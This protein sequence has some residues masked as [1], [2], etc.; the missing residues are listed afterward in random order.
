[1]GDIDASGTSGHADIKGSGVSTVDCESRPVTK[2]AGSQDITVDFG[3]CLPSG[4]EIETM[5][6]CSDQDTIHVCVKDDNV[7][8]IKICGD[9]K[10]KAVDFV[11]VNAESTCTGGDAP[12]AQSEYEG[13]VSVLGHGETLNVKILDI[14]T[15]GTSG[16][17]DIKGSGISTVDCENKPVTKASGS[18]DLTVDFGSCL[19][20]GIEITTLKV[21]SD[22]SM[23]HACVK[24]HNIGGIQIC[25][26]LKKKG[27]V[28]V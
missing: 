7:G 13:S 8:G 28:M 18:Q 6:V 27:M 10:K 15:S 25:M 26:D 12:P 20:S 17:A 4:I 1:M 23:I 3:S 21:C 19:P 2:K 5:Q 11:A 9:L 14:D 22:Q 24:D 16:H